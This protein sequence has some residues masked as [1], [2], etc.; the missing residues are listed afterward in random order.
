L[1][2]SFP[3]KLK[4]ANFVRA[5]KK[6][7]KLFNFASVVSAS[8]TTKSLSYEEIAGNAFIFYIAGN[9]TTSSIIAYTLFEL[10]QNEDLMRRAKEDIKLTLGKHEGE[11]TYESVQE[12]KFI[13][14]C[15]KE[16]LRKSTQLQ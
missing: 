7:C 11:I 14:L 10:T 8:K 16:T 3:F 15:V 4:L 2:K 13:D 12:M 6:L 1:R 9:E 5:A